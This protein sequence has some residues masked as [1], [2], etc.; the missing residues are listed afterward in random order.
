MKVQNGCTESSRHIVG[1]FSDKKIN[2]PIS[3]KANNLILRYFEGDSRNC[4]GERKTAKKWPNFTVAKSASKEFALIVC[5]KA[6]QDVSKRRE[7]TENGEKDCTSSLDSKS[8]PDWERNR[9]RTCL[10]YRCHWSVTINII[11]R[12][13]V[14]SSEDALERCEELETLCLVGTGPYGDIDSR[15]K[16][17]CRLWRYWGKSRVKEIEI[18]AES[19]IAR[20]RMSPKM[21]ALH[22]HLE[23]TIVIVEPQRTWWR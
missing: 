14:M 6:L 10:A 16:K 1:I 17:C 12:T 13:A 21:S 22:L 11:R 5:E 8:L 20:A 18:S 2:I 3:S 23:T 7:E 4:V 19:L 15:Y 9:R